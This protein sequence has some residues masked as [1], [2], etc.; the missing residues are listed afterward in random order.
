MVSSR[1]MFTQGAV[2]FSPPGSGYA[3]DV[4]LAPAFTT[5][6][7]NALAKPTKLEKREALDAV[8]KDF[9]DVFPIKLEIGGTLS[10]HSMETF[11]R[12]VRY[13]LVKAVRI[14]TDRIGGL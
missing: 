1:Y 5:A 7:D 14:C 11:K 9:G 12:S 2:N 6:V 3:D 4:Q 8:F 10:A 13:L